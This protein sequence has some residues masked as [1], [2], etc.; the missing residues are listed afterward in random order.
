MANGDTQPVNAVIA[1]ALEKAGVPP[2]NIDLPPG[3]ESNEPANE[4]NVPNLDGS[5]KGE[6]K[7]A[8]REPEE[9]P[10]EP[11][12]EPSKT[13][14][15]EP[16]VQPL[17]KAEIEAAITEASSKFQSIMDKKINALQFQMQQTIGALNQF[18]QSQED[19][20]ISG[21]P[22]DEQTQRRLE[23]LESG[24]K[25][26]KIQIAQTPQADQAAQQLFQYLAD[27]ADVAGL[28]IDDGRLDWSGNLSPATNGSTIVANFKASVKAALI[29]D[30]TKVIQDLKDGGN[31]EIQKIRKKAGVDK[32]STSGPG[33][34][35]LPDVS[36]MTP[37]EKIE[38]GYKVQEEL[39][40]VAK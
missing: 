21:L 10:S 31:K 22:A 36:K 12:A 40:Q 33:G 17:G 34:A 19:S 5:L 39:S 14:P 7:G 3:S 9:E 38:Y 20:S 27:M 35:G 37:M 32:V 18:F 24:P 30:Q 2:R 8:E 1:A 25:Q 6:V 26:P 29:A 11:E 23:R 15:G 13:K 4:A 28:K 16:T